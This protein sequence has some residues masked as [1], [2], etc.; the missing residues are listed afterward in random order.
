MSGRRRRCLPL[1]RATLRTT[2]GGRPA[3]EVPTPWL[4]LRARQQARARLRCSMAGA[5]VA[6]LEGRRRSPRSR[7]GASTATHARPRHAAPSPSAAPRYRRALRARATRWRRSRG[8]R[9][10]A[11]GAESHVGARAWRDQVAASDT[12]PSCVSHEHAPGFRPLPTAS[13]SIPPAGDN[14][15]RRLARRPAATRRSCVR[16]GRGRCPRTSSP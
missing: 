5:G 14:G 13:C 10:D 1:A 9:H 3:R 4:T 12:T 7:P 16:P 6:G 11:R 8:P 2:A 15:A